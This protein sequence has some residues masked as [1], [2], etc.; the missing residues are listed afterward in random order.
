MNAHDRRVFRRAVGRALAEGPE[1]L[2]R[3][4]KANGYRESLRGRA[5]VLRAA[6]KLVDGWRAWRV[7]EAFVSVLVDGF[8]L[9]Y[10]SMPASWFDPTRGMAGEIG[11]TMPRSVVVRHNVEVRVDRVHA[12]APF[13]AQFGFGLVTQRGMHLLVGL[14]A[15]PGYAFACVP[16][17]I[18]SAPVTEPGMLS[19]VLASLAI[20]DPATVAWDA[21]VGQ[22]HPV[23]RLLRS[24]A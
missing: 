16:G 5:R 13:H 24:A 3:A 12:P 4:A 18:A 17:T 15:V 8:L 7:P 9:T 11:G 23:D 10:Q 20:D 22:F 6:R 1:G 19:R 14:G 21:Y 2:A